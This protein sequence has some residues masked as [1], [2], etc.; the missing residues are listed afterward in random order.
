MKNNT[1]FWTAFFE[2]LKFIFTLGISHIDKRKNNL[3]NEK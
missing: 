3:N 1:T 2:V